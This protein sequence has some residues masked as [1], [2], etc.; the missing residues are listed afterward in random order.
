MILT[1]K[2]I[3][4]HVH[5][6]TPEWLD[7]SLRG[8][9]EAAEAYFRS[10]VARRSL[11]ELAQDYA[12]IDTVAVLLAWDA[13]TATGRPRVPNEL[14]A[15]ACRD[16]P[17]NFVGFGS[18]DPLKGESAVDELEAISAAGLKGVK[19][20]PSL[21]AF[22]PDDERFWPLYER[23]EE[24]GLNVLFHT[25]TSGIG[26]GQPGGQGIRL[27]YARPIRLDAVAASFPNLNVIAAHFGYPWHL[28]LLAMALHKTNIYIDISGWAPKYIPSEVV[29]EMKG[30]LQNQFL[31]GSDYPFI[32]PERCLEEIA[33]LQIPEAALQK[34]LTGNGKRLLGLS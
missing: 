33:E 15:D 32:K 14:V 1:V 20:H 4:C 25:G 27:D 11:D 12:A 29:R 23:C 21:Q 24:L 10:K 18:V 3:D 9:V 34:V 5:L 28:E 2:A 19:L 30:R 17:S 7:V 22:A 16:H 26:A 8:Y 6:P 31:F 13:E